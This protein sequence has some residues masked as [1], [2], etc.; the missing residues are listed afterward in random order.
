MPVLFVLEETRAGT[1]LIE[2]DVRRFAAGLPAGKAGENEATFGQVAKSTA[3]TRNRIPGRLSYFFQ[4]T[5]GFLVLP[6]AVVFLSVVSAAVSPSGWLVPAGRVVLLVFLSGHTALNL[7]EYIRYCGIEAKRRAAIRFAWLFGGLIAS[8][9]L[10][11]ALLLPAVE[12]AREAARRTQCII[13]LKQIG[14]AMFNY[15]SHW[16]CL[17]PAMIADASGR[18]MHSWRVLLLPYLG[19]NSL[20]SSYNF[21][22]PWDGPDNI[23]LEDR[24]PAVY[25]CPSDKNAPPNTTN[26]M[27]LTGPGGAFLSTF[28]PSLSSISDGISNTLLTIESPAKSILWLEPTDISV[29]GFIEFNSRYERGEIRPNHNWVSQCLMMD[30]SVRALRSSTPPNIIRAISTPS[31]GEVISTESY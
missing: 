11:T 8:S 15:E 9:V 27:V 5:F 16:D 13:N 19:E 14:I 2:A 6:I 1:E 21:D 29:E 3:S 24:M 23:Q 20:Y 28:A 25:R 4:A 30:G 31:G 17:P 18:P 7:R 26:Y 12:A 10:I 22:Q